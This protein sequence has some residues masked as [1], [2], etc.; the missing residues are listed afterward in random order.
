MIHFMNLNPSPFCL[1]SKKL[2]T[3]EL[4][5]NDSKRQ[6]ICIDD[7][8]EFTNTENSELKLLVKVINLY[9]FSS[10]K[11]LYQVL[12]MQ[13]CGYMPKELP[14]ADASDMDAYYSM[15]KQAQYGVL[16]I[17]VELLKVYLKKQT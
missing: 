10:F 3:I 13:K 2:K 8:I 14:K 9:R 11:E 4:R 15:E 16:G 12:P 1:M 6:L 5:L 7:E 17:E